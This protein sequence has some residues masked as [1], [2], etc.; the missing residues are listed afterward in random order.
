M[1]TE[2]AKEALA[3]GRGVVELVL[4]RRLLPAEQLEAILRPETLA[5]LGPKPPTP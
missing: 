1:A 2:L 3:T 4:E 5:N